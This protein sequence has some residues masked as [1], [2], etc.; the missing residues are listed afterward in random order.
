M[1]LGCH[2][3]ND[4]FD[5]IEPLLD[6]VFDNPMDEEFVLHDPSEHCQLMLGLWGIETYH[7]D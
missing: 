3:P 4:L 7:C 2:I 5:Q 6:C 1:K